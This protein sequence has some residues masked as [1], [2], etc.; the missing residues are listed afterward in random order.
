MPRAR[1]LTTLAT[2]VALVAALLALAGCS[3]TESPEPAPSPSPSVSAT[4][5]A[6]APAPT[7]DPEASATE[8]RPFFDETVREVLSDDRTPGGAAIIRALVAAGFPKDSLEVTFDRT[9]I[10]LEADNVQFSALV[11]EECLIG[12]VGNVKYRSRVMP[13]LGSGRCFIGTTRP[14]NFVD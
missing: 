12:Q 13:V 7:Y 2:S 8:L 3:P 9:A 5:E 10:D 11:G 1:A 4:S 6:P 14:L